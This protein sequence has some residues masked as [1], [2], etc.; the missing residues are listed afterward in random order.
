MA[1]DKFF[2]MGGYAG[3]V[4]TAL[5]LSALVLIVLLG[6]S[7]RFLKTQKDMLERLEAGAA[8]TDRGDGA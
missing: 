8:Q 4:W 1:W 6:T 3:Y 2:A 5:G 7:T